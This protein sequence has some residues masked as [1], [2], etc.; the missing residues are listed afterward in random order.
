MVDD[1]D[2]KLSLT[3]NEIASFLRVD[4]EE[5]SNQLINVEVT[6]DGSGD[7]MC[8]LNHCSFLKE[9]FLCFF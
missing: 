7:S 4:D 6:V 8:R 3:Q 2:S 5:L 9:C 1:P